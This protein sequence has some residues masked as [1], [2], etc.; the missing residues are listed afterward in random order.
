MAILWNFLSAVRRQ[1]PPEPLIFTS[2]D[3][4]DTADRMDQLFVK[5]LI[6][7]FAQITDINIDH[8][9]LTLTPIIPA[10]RLKLFARQHDIAVTHHI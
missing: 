6:D 3:I 7:L 5:A 8:I 9:R 2:K 10:V 1:S 4:A